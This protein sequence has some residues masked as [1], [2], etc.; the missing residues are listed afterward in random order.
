MI[1]TYCILK[2]N[3]FFA[4]KIRQN[5][6]RLIGIFILV[7]KVKVKA[8][9]ANHELDLEDKLND[10]LKEIKEEKIVDIKYCVSVEGFMDKE[11]IYCFSALVIYKD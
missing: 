3:Y 7:I 1:I 4:S 6:R 8:F 2:I 10:F 11:Q 9:D 5:N